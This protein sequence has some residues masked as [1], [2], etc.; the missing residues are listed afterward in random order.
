MM[1]V[2]V[3]IFALCWL[4]QN[5]YFVLS[6]VWESITHDTRAQHYYLIFFWMAMS[7]AMYNPILYCWMNLRYARWLA[8]R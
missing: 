6:H 4:P 7:Q 5:V 2:V 8:P 3:V 1:I